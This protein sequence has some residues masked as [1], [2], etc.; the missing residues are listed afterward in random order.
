MASLRFRADL[1]EVEDS[2][3]PR[4]AKL[5]DAVSGRVARLSRVD[6]AALRS[7]GKPG[8]EAMHGRSGRNPREA[9]GLVG[10]AMRMGLMTL[11][12]PAKHDGWSRFWA[13]G[14]SRLLCVRIPLVT[15]DRLADGLARRAGFLFHPLGILA[16]S[17]MILLAAASVLAG[18][19]RGVQ[20]AGRLQLWGQQSFGGWLGIA[21]VFVATKVAHE[22]GHAAA[23]RR[24]GVACGEI[25]VMLFAGVPCP[26]CD[27]SLVSR[28]DSVW[29]RAGV[30]MAGIY[31]ELV[32]ATVA[33]V[34][35]WASGPGPVQAIALNVMIVCGA[36][37]VLFNANPLMRLDGYYVLSDVVGTANLRGRAQAAWRGLVTSRMGGWTR[38]RVG[39]TSAEVALAAYHAASAV[40]RVG[41]MV[42]I[43]WM[44]VR[45][46][47]SIELR[48][49][50]IGLVFVLAVPLV[51]VVAGGLYRMMFGFGAWGET[52]VWRRIAILVGGLAAGG[53]IL[54]TPI[55]REIV[56]VGV[57]DV[58]GATAVHPAQNGWVVDV[59]SDYAT[60]VAEGD[61]LAEL[62]DPKLR[63]ELV[64]WDSRKRLAEL[65]S[66]ALSRRALSGDSPDLAWDLDAANRRLVQSHWRSL[67][68]RRER[69][70]V[71]SPAG[72]VLLPP[73]VARPEKGR[74]TEWGVSPVSR[75]FE[76]IRGSYADSR[77]SLARVGDPNRCCV[78][79]F[80]DASHRRLIRPGQAVR[81]VGDFGDFSAKPWTVDTIVGSISEIAASNDQAGPGDSV[82]SPWGVSGQRFDVRCDCPVGSFVDSGDGSGVSGAVAGLSVIPIG[83]EVLARIR[84]GDES[85]WQRITRSIREVSGG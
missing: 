27:V 70:I 39:W 24:I 45:V 49:L 42:A 36:S 80:V 74:G 18:W 66:A 29:H 28:S 17:V 81:L 1:I 82:G 51:A 69:L 22:L 72:G 53:L 78:T 79:L 55:R 3:D 64:A 4:R 59:G 23:C 85:V 7:V 2:R 48:P 61:T 32:L 13:S 52:K 68:E 44:V 63:F 50:G 83:G 6:L 62:D 38:G 19:D 60:V 31:V 57:L 40:Y 47:D 5:I 56:V 21:I 58:A 43:G 20:S 75:R 26:Y 11:R 71:R 46:S 30:M 65:Q 8:E 33:T 84:V 37:T 73:E 34:V 54:F 16:W 25:G 41:V 10:E 9:A 15:V 76:D 12:A 35:W 67:V 77:R 14:P